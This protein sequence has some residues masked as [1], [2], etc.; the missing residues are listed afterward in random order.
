TQGPATSV[1]TFNPTASDNCPGLGPVVCNP[2][3]GSALAPGVHTIHCSVTDAAGN[4]SACSFH[5][6]VILNHA[7]TVTNP[8]P[9]QVGIFGADFNFTIPPDTF[10]DEDARQT[11]TYAA[12]DLP[13]GINF[14]PETATFNGTFGAAGRFTVSVTAT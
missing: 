9:D 11:F 6:T 5:V 12:F 7:V 8:I 1:V 4:S 13:P 2:P 10:A 3:S 14:T